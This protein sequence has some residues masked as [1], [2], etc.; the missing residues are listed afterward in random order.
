MIEF[1][2]RMGDDTISQL[3]DAEDIIIDLSVPLLTEELNR[4]SDHDHLFSVRFITRD[5]DRMVE[6]L[7]NQMI[8]ESHLAHLS[9]RSKT[10]YVSICAP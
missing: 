4:Y 8:H 1:C 5:I 3:D 6:S 10:Y 9:L 7:S 2:R